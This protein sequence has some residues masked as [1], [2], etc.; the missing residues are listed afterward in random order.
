MGFSIR[1]VD[2]DGQARKSARVAAR[3][4]RI[5]GGAVSEYTDADG[6]ANID[7]PNLPETLIISVDGDDQGEHVLDDGDTLSFT[8]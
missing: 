7:W 5:L 3:S 2:D 8:V 4:T 6:W 1:V